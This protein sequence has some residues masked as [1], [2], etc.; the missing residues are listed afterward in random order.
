M[1]CV[2]LHH[3]HNIIRLSFALLIV[4]ALLSSTIPF[5]YARM[6]QAN[7]G[8][9]QRVRGNPNP[10]EGTFPNLNEIRQAQQ[11]EPEAPLE[12]PSD[13]RSRRLS[14]HP[15]ATRGSILHER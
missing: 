2:P 10:P 4:A 6:Q 14:S 8:N 11:P 9:Q 13:I 3:S 12:M 15:T 1:S 7:N 5:S